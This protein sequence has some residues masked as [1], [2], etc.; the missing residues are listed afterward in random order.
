MGLRGRGEQIAATV[1]LM[2]RISATTGQD[3]HEFVRTAFR[4]LFFLAV[5]AIVHCS[6]WNS[7]ELC[8][9]DGPEGSP[10]N[11]ARDDGRFWR[12]WNGSSP[13]PCENSNRLRSRGEFGV[14]ALLRALFPRSSGF[15]RVAGPPPKRRPVLGASRG[16][17]GAAI[18]RLADRAYADRLSAFTRR[19]RF[20]P[21][22][23]P[24]APPPGTDR[25]PWPLPSDAARRGRDDRRHRLPVGRPAEDSA[26]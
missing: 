8:L 6:D 13:T 11:A 21:D 24:T 17:I 20:P 14:G 22:R 9:V 23:T 4:R 7:C 1:Q 5:G 2:R 25:P 19:R 26:G 3:Q 16:V 12:S 10:S 18:N 15:I